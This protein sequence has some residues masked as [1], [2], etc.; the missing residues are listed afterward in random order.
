MDSA[1]APAGTLLK[2]EREVDPAAYLLPPA[3]ALSRII[4]QSEKLTGSLVPVSAFI[5]WPYTPRLLPDGHPIAAWA[6]GTS[7]ISADAAPSH[8]KTLWQHFLGPYQLALQGYVVVAADYAGL[9]VEKTARGETI[10]HEYL[11]GPSQ[12]ND[13]VYSVQAAQAAF[14]ELSKKFVVIGHSQGGGAA[15]A[16]SERQAIKPIPGYLGGVAVSPVTRLLD[17]PEDFLPILGAA[18]CPAVA[19]V[20]LDFDPRTLM[21]EDG[22]KRYDLIRQTGGCSGT[23]LSLL[24]GAELFLPNWT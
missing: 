10:V 17:E 2:V 9:A 8:L 15:W 23:G 24:M 20:F 7:G 6:H 13:V 21:T 4:F 3:T 1:G 14:A 16:V 5:V 18:I 22:I 19:S 11:S 12:A